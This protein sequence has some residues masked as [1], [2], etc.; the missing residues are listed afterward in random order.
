ML[1]H[2]FRSGADF[3]VKI[4]TAIFS[5]LIIVFSLTIHE[6]SHGLTALALGIWFLEAQLPPLVPVPGIKLGLS[7]IVTLFALFRL[8]PADAAAVLLTR[9]LLASLFGGQAVSLLFSLCGGLLAL[10]R[11]NRRK[12]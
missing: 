5:I 9:V 6:V 2:I 7:N 10:D 3:K 4:T 8:G 12:E 1:L 11:I